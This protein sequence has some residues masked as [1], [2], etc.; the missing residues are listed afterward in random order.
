MSI[1][2]VVS[3]ESDEAAAIYEYSHDRISLINNRHFSAP[4]SDAETAQR[5]VEEHAP[6]FLSRRKQIVE[7]KREELQVGVF[8]PSIAR[9]IYPTK[10]RG[11]ENRNSHVEPAVIA[12]IRR[13]IG[14][15]ARNLE[16]CFDVSSPYEDNFNTFGV[17]YESI[18]L[19]AC[20]GIENLFVKILQDNGVR[21]DRYTTNDFIRLNTMMRL[22]EYEAKLARYPWLTPFAPFR[23]WNPAEP[24][25]S[26]LW[27]DAYNKLKHDKMNCQNKATMRNA[28]DATL[29]F[30][31]LFHGIYGSAVSSNFFQRDDDDFRMVRFP[32]WNYRE[33]YFEAEGGVWS[34]EFAKIP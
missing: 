2:F 21:L 29:A 15:L 1:C 32:N 3:T 16:Q 9:P 17:S 23:T 11:L 7:I 26:L 13:D 33:N 8:H 6:Q 27:Y 22:G 12:T 20:I 28:I 24:T 18:I 5:I 30:W 14:L 10:R 31:I 34:M 4:S 19:F 25:K